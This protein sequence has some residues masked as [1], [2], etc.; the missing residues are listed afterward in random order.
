[1]R[2]NLLKKTVDLSA[3]K[4]KNHLLKTTPNINIG[5]TP[6]GQRKTNDFKPPQRPVVSSYQKPKDSVYNNRARSS[7]KSDT[8]DIKSSHSIEPKKR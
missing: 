2:Q 7:G 6:T 5:G 3:E 1:V 4:N 8:S